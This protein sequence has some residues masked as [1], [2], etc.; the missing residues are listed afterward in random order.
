VSNDRIAE[1]SREVFVHR[2]KKATLHFVPHHLAHAHVR[3]PFLGYA[4]SGILTIDRLGEK[5]SRFFACAGGMEFALFEETMPPDRSA[6]S[7]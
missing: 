5:S 2:P 6:F 1:T 3:F 4:E 7:P